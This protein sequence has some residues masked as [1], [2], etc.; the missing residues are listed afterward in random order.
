M[1]LSWANVPLYW[2][3]QWFP[4]YS[5]GIG[6]SLVFASSQPSSV[7]SPSPP[8]PDFMLPSPSFIL[9]IESDYPAGKIPDTRSDAENGL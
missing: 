8:S 4:P 5:M 7:N 1:M 6:L 9:D 2:A 3:W